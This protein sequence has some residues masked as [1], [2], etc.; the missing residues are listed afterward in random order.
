ML[1]PELL[2]S[3]QKLCAPPERFVVISHVRPDGDA[4][5]ST[6][7]LG[8]SLQAQ[9][10]DVQFINA[11]GLA[12]SFPFLPRSQHLTVTP[13]T[14]PESDRLIIAVDCADQKRLGSAFEQWGRKPDVNID[15]HLS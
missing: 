6:L 4:Y 1:N 7:G 14:A 11:D 3:L 13:T 9:G 8:L 10:K 2:S 12:P 15:H 5:G